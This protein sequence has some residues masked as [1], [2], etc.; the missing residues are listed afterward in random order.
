MGYNQNQMDAV[1]YLVESGDSELLSSQDNDGNTPLHIAQNK[2]LIQYLLSI[3]RPNIREMKNKEGDK[4]E[5]RWEPEVKEYID[6]ISTAVDAFSD[7]LQCPICFET[8]NDVYFIPNC[9]HHFCKQCIT[10]S[11]QQRKD[12]SCPICRGKFRPRDIREDPLVGPILQSKLLKAERKK[13]EDMN[14]VQTQLLEAKEEN[15]NLL[16]E[17]ITLKRKYNEL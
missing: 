3:S 14:N 2:E 4:A 9:H 12:G 13:Q 1:K 11:I 5:D 17:L 8:M 15:R 7:D 16:D 6:L 10:Q